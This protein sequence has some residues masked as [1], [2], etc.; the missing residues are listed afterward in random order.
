MEC[1]RKN[2]VIVGGGITGLSAAFYLSKRMEELQ[3]PMDITLVEKNDRFGGKIQ[4]LRRDGFIIEQG[5]DSFLARKLPII[6]LTKE[7]GLEDEL[8]ATN[9]QAKANFILHKNKLHPMPLGLVLGIPTQVSPFIRTGLI[10][11]AGKIRA[12]LDLV[13]PKRQHTSDESLGD[14][15]RRR[16]GREVLDHITE[17]LLAGIYAGDTQYLSLQATFPQ[18]KQLEEEHRSIILGMLAGKKKP[19]SGSGLPDIARK[20]LFLTYKQGLATLVDRLAA[21]LQSRSIRTMTGQGVMRFVREEGR[22]KLTLDQGTELEADAVIMAL[23]AFEAARLLPELP[24]ARWLEHIS[25][26]SVANVALAYRQHDI[27]FPLNGSGFV[28]PRKEGRFI[29]ACT[30]SSSKWPHTAPSGRLLLRTYV[31]RSG[32]QEWTRLSDEELIHGV[33]SDLRALMGITA[34][35]EFA[36]I[37]RCHQSMPQYPVGHVE[38]WGRLQAQLRSHTPGLYLCGAGYEGV[39]IP[40]C[41]QQGKRAAEQLL[42]FVQAGQSQHL[43]GS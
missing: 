40:D 37:T 15:I 11:P 31:G 13:L 3:V 20:S 28:V 32:A 25:Y 22:Y 33:V 8:T 35:P 16:L 21:A 7:L 17:P 23:P 30:W 38:R 10:S 18:F 24:D 19:Q 27:P 26:A 6:A 1:K 9:P 34:E 14:F 36:E 12:A 41:I 42:G 2:V 4:T 29:T 5:P 39:G 43:H